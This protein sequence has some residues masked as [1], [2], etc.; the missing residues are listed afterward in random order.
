MSLALKI[1]FIFDN[2]IYYSLINI[3]S[4]K[5][6]KIKDLY[7]ICSTIDPGTAFHCFGTAFES[8]SVE[9]VEHSVE[10]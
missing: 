3:Q 1:N 10:H 6:I 5:I 7:G 8:A 9:N 4:I 2:N